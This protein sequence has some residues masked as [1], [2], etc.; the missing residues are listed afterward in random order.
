MNNKSPF[1]NS[2]AEAVNMMWYNIVKSLSLTLYGDPVIYKMQNESLSELKA[3]LGYK[4]EQ[5]NN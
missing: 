4:I 1:E 2:V 5:N 3:T